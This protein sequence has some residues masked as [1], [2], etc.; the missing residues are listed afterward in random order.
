MEKVINVNNLTKKF[1]DF[2][3]VDNISFDVNKGTIFGFLGPNGAGK[4]T[5]IK[6]LTGVLKPT[7]GDI[8][9]FGLNFEKNEL[10]IKS[11]IGVIPEEPVIYENLKGREFLEFIMKI[12]NKYEKSTTSKLE[13]LI[14]TF[15]INFL[16]KYVSEMSHGMKQKLLLLSVLMREPQLMFLDEPT[17][18]LDAKSIKILQIYLQK[19]VERGKTVFLT[20]HILD[21][22]QKLCTHIAIIDK[23]KILLSGEK[24]EILTKAQTNLEEFF[25]KITGESE[26]LES[27]KDSLI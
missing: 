26:H 8:N 16:E 2:I 5:T 20:T 17:V 10:K 1:R 9:I 25:L 22:A 19:M 18:G 6:M 23:G 21:I 24:D 13:S 4:T 12:Y 27:F 3:A 15:D 14:K 11:E 7:S